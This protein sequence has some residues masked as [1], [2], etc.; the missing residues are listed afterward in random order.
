M[1][2]T[3]NREIAEY[4]FDKMR[5]FGFKP[6]D[7]E[8]GDGYF[9]FDMG[10]DSV[11]HFRMK[12]VW[13]HWKFGMW[14]SSEYLSEDYRNSYVKEYDEPEEWK[15]IQ[16]FCQH[17]HVIDKFKPSRSALCVSYDVEDWCEKEKHPNT[18]WELEHML[19]MIKNH[20][21]ICFDGFCGECV[22]YRA[23]S[24]LIDFIEY[25]TQW[26]WEHIKKFIL[27]H[28]WYT[29]TKAKIK[30]AEKSKCIK[31]IEFH[32][33][34][35]EN[36]GWSTSHLYSVIPIFTKDSTEEEQCK[37]MDKWFKKEKYG[38]Y[39]YYDYVIEV[40]E[41]KIEGSDKIYTFV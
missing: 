14:I 40:L 4:M 16:V 38:E 17:D 24:F 2:L 1:K 26:Y 15:L 23:N 10:E 36:P 18:F 5:E 11:V 25:E 27:K 12:G 37:W 31:G 7:I 32:D 39:G 33:F 20:P 3:Q 34:E 8:Y 41:C 30:L 28:F 21:V 13:R 6:Y 22:G 29:Y 19:K 9:L 35:K